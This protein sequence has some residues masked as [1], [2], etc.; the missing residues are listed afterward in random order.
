MYRYEL[1]YGELEG[2]KIGKIRDLA[3]ECVDQWI[4]L[5]TIE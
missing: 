4:V 3:S 2:G 1:D 5:A